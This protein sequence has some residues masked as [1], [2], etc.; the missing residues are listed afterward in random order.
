M[1]GNSLVVAGGGFAKTEPTAQVVSG[2]VLYAAG[3]QPRDAAF[4]R[5]S[6]D[7]GFRVKENTYKL[8]C[9]PWAQ[10]SATLAESSM[11]F[12][13]QPGP[14]NIDVLSSVHTVDVSYEKVTFAHI[15]ADAADYATLISP[16]ILIVALAYFAFAVGMEDIAN[17]MLLVWLLAFFVWY[18]FRP[19]VAV[20]GTSGVSPLSTWVEFKRKDKKDLED[21]FLDKKYEGKNP[22]NNSPGNWQATATSWKHTFTTFCCIPTGA[23]EVSVGDSHLRVHKTTGILP[24]M[25]AKDTFIIMTDNIKWIH[26]SSSGRS[27]RHLFTV[28]LVLF[29]VLLVSTM[30]PVLFRRRRLEEW[31]GGPDPN[32]SA[33][34]FGGGFD[35]VQG[36]EGLLSI[37]FLVAPLA[38]L[39]ILL[40]LL[41]WLGNTS[42]TMGFAFVGAPPGG[43]VGGGALYKG[44]W[45][46]TIPRDGLGIGSNARDEIMYKF[47]STK[48]GRRCS[49]D[50]VPVQTWWG[51]DKDHG[52]KAKVT[53]E[54]HSD[55][56]LVRREAVC[57]GCFTC[58]G[59]E[60][61]YACVDLLLRPS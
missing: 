19:C 20:F 57:C 58:C 29:V 43:T 42:A 44:T 56:V 1:D 38:P 18:W 16:T 27:I 11:N 35:A 13:R 26:F 52:P 5:K 55:Y 37:I 31:S 25:K 34:G 51:M 60:D 15:V 2:G 48:T 21:R 45:G 39:I 41:H 4:F 30:V 22:A 50:D 47:L 40:M 17:E 7:E 46:S 6:L 12:R 28:L 61:V 33:L 49:T 54:L 3:D 14:C 9:I 59:K 36:L 24:W 10:H 8:K 23:D 32:N 53:L